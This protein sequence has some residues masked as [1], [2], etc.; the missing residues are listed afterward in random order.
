MESETWQLAAT[1]PFYSF[2][3]NRQREGDQCFWLAHRR[4]SNRPNDEGTDISLSL[5]DISLRPM[6]PDTD[7]LTVRTTCTNRDLP[8]R[9]P[10]GSEA[11]AFELEGTAAI[12]LLFP[13][14]NPTPPLRPPPGQR[15][16]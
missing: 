4:T 6:R 10:F 7:T 5:V 8:A 2:H 15:P 1:E 13:L 16:L 9:L 12:K 3:P 14:N 11:G